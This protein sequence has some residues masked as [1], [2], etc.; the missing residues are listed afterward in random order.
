[1]QPKAFFSLRS[2]RDLVEEGDSYWGRG[3]SF[4]FPVAYL[5]IGAALSIATAGL[6]A[7][8]GLL[9]AKRPAGHESQLALRMFAL[10]WFSAGVVLLLSGMPSILGAF[11]IFDAGLALA[12]TY[13]LSVPLASALCGLVSY[14][15]FVYTGSR[16][17]LRW[18]VAGYA[19][20]FL[21]EL[22]YF[23]SF[24]PRELVATEWSVRAVAQTRP[25]VWLSAAFGIAV[26]VPVLACAV[27]Y[28]ALYFR[29][30]QRDQRFR[31]ALV[32]SAF[33]LWFGP[34]LFGF[35]VGWD[36]ADWFPLVYEGPG[37]VASAMIL[38]AN[39][40]PR[41][42]RQWLTTDSGA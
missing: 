17:A 32:S 18:I 19:L 36:R 3:L 12:T 30:T 34:L 22:Y 38:L 15:V 5:W 21:F 10:W 42:V 28:G 11:G 29:V 40:P 27:S 1:M 7:Y 16:T 37:V 2:E 13:I 41:R 8:V 39:H 23:G 35:I 33:L 31:V 9:T 20:F 25:A 4:A 6:L 14:L 24:G 26:A